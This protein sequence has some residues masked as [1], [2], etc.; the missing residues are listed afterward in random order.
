MEID[1]FTLHTDTFI[2]TE[3]PSEYAKIE[4]WNEGTVEA[5]FDGKT[6]R[7]RCIAPGGKQTEWTI[8]GLCARYATGTKLWHATIRHSG[9]RVLSVWT[10]FESRSGR[11]SQP[12][13]C[14]F[15]ADV[16]EQHVSKR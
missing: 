14:G 12:R 3:T 8:Y 6:R 7:V 5:T 9:N 1:M 16:G 13:V 10:G 15:M 4:G 2:A 11:Y